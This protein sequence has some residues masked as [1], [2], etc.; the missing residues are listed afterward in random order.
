[1][2]TVALAPVVQLNRAVVSLRVS[3]DD[4]VPADVTRLLAT[5]PSMAYA[6]GDEI[7]S[8]HGAVRIAKF[9]FWSCAG[10]E[11]EPADIDAQVAQLLQRLTP[12]LD[13]WRQLADRFQIDLFCGWFMEHLNEGVQISPTTL[14]ALAERQIVLSLDIYGYGDEASKA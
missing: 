3:G 9:G 10:P 12:N 14:M 13:V 11:T 4:L 5:N 6:R 7:P 2:R 8:K 1:M